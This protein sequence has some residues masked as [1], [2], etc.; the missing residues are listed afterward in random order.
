MKKIIYPFIILLAIVCVA[1]FAFWWYRADHLKKIVVAS[2]EN[3]ERANGVHIQYDDIEKRGFPFNVELGIIDP[4]IIF[5]DQTEKILQDPIEIFL[6]GTLVLGTRMWES[7]AWI[8]IDGNTHF[9]RI[10][11]E[12]DEESE[13]AEDKHWIL[14]GKLLFS[15]P[16]HH[17][18]TYDEAGACRCFDDLTLQIN[19]LRFSHAKP[20]PKNLIFSLENSLFHFKLSKQNELMNDF[21]VELD[22]HNFNFYPHKEL[23]NRLFPGLIGNEMQFLLTER[24]KHSS[25]FVAHGTLP[26]SEY[27]IKSITDKKL[28]PF[29]I[30]IDKSFVK[31]D[32]AEAFVKGKIE[33][34]NPRDQIFQGHVSYDSYHQF[35]EKYREA[36]IQTIE[37]MAELT[38][39]NPSLDSKESEFWVAHTKDIAELVPDLSQFGKI[40]SQMDL[41]LK[42]V[43]DQ[44]S[45]PP[46]GV[47]H[48]PGITVENESGFNY[49]LDLLKLNQFNLHTDL[50]GGELAGEYKEKDF[51]LPSGHV[52]IKMKNYRELIKDATEYYQ[53]WYLMLNKAEFPDRESLPKVAPNFV[54]KT[55]SL[56]QAISDDPKAEKNPI[57]ITVQIDSDHPE[58]FKVG[59]LGFFEFMN[60]WIQFA[61]ELSP[62][63][64]KSG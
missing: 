44:E 54:E 56:L 26:N 64:F 58:N 14:G 46:K 1:Y 45:A 25:S 12:A 27:F 63:S 50:Y 33:L 57:E 53:R 15:W 10:A 43:S 34:E 18:L 31:D 13:E 2:I 4:L 29:S 8:G 39:M 5:H 7:K 32:L 11:E 48:V 9:T 42:L 3:F 22:I 24:G 62:D 17:L 37:M 28:F 49:R 59:T 41:N 16:S 19:N 20:D 36:L 38:K 40:I 52:T 35:S 21:L 61:M 60:V 55:I 51:S 30:M 47:D 23:Y 6:E